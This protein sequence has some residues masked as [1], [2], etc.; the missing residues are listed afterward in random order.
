LAAAGAG[1]PPGHLAA[2][3]VVW[4]QDE[5]VVINND[6]GRDPVPSLYKGRHHMNVCKP[7][8]GFRDPVD[9]VVAALNS[10]P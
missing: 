2:A 6:F 9:A 1:P 10:F 8:S 7:A 3:A 5:R 4:A